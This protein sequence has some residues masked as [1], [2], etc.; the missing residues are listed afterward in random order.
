MKTLGA[1]E[2]KAKCLK[3][4]DQVA[5]T[6]E[7]VVITKHGRPVSRLVPFRKPA[8]TLIGL[9]KGKARI[10]GDIMEP[11]KVKWEAMQ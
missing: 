9:H 2:F 8:K 1:G 4:M 6:G 10:L 3:V 7:E 5:A 11:I